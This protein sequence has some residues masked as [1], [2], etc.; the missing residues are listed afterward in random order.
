MNQMRATSFK[1]QD[2]PYFEDSS[3]LFDFIARRPWAAYLDSGHPY[4]HQGRF[5]ILTSDPRVT[6]TTRGKLT[7]IRDRAGTRLSR[8]DPFAL[9]D[10]A[11]GPRL[12]RDNQGLPFCGGA[13]GYWGYD[14]SRRIER[15][16]SLAQDAEGLPEMAIGIYDWALVV[17]HRDKCSRLLGRLQ[18][19]EAWEN[20]RGCFTGPRPADA[21]PAFRV[22]GEVRANMT[23]NEYVSALRR[24]KR[25]IRDGDCYQVNFAQRFSVPAEGD[26]LQLYKGLRRFN[27]APFGAFLNTPYGQILSSSPERFLRLR[28]KRVETR[29]I[30][31]TLARA[32]DPAQDQA[33]ISA[34]RHSAKDRAE[35]LMIVDLLRNDIGKTCAFGS[36]RVTDLFAV[37]SFARVHHLVSTVRGRLAP[38]ENALT[39]LRGCFPG[40]SVTGAPKLRAMQIIEE[41]EPQRRGVYCGAIG[42]IGFDGNMDTNIAIRTLVH[43]RNLTRFWAGGGIVADSDVQAEYQETLDKAAAILDLLQ[44]VRADGIRP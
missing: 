11:L 1:V 8:T 10:E 2:L 7:E 34:L 32:P 14:L 3:R 36:I 15:L 39:L 13:L 43:S 5:D 38:G 22:T 20:L 31:G 6:L 35:N 16:P 40:G 41:L 37:E 26:P 29:P 33:R 19:N 30:K 9:V 12:Q 42:Y 24:I 28:D 4:A 23:R 44:T 17:D 21:E 27:P 25:Y 18:D